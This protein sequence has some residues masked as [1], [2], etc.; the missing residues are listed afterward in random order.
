MNKAEVRELA[1]AFKFVDDNGAE[2]ASL[3]DE[4]RRPKVISL[5]QRFGECTIRITQRYQDFLE[6]STAIQN[7]GQLPNAEAGRFAQFRLVD[8]VE[9]FHQQIYAGL[10]YLIAIL[11]FVAGSG[12]EPRYAT[13]SNSKFLRQILEEFRSRSQIVD[14]INLLENSTA[15]RSK[16]VDHPAA[17]IMQD[18]MTQDYFGKCYVIYFDPFDQEAES[19]YVGVPDPTSPKYRPPV[20]GKSFFV[21]PDPVDTFEAFNTLGRAALN[22]MIGQ[23]KRVRNR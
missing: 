10:S 4:E 19:D 13:T 18:W 14:A 15:F 9:A 5:L 12:K 6:T 8:R 3:V 11:N 1:S 16:F 20:G 21:A 22:R 17:N 2:L 23:R 7:M